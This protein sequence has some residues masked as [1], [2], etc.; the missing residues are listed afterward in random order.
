M[1]CKW[2]EVLCRSEEWYCVLQ[3]GLWCSH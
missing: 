1:V 2:I 3:R